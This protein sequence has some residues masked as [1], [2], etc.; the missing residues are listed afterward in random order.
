MAYANEKCKIENAKNDGEKIQ[1][2]NIPG[3]SFCI[4]HFEF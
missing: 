2:L 4:L 3:Q 1:P